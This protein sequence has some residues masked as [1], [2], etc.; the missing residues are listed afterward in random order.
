MSETKLQNVFGQGIRPGHP[1]ELM[2][3]TGADAGSI[4]PLNITNPKISI[5]ADLRLE[6][7][8]ELISGANKNDYHFKNIDLKR[9]VPSIKYYDIRTV[10]DGELTS[11]KKDKIRIT[12]AIEVGHIF[13]LGTKYSEALGSTFLDEQGNS[14]PIIMG[15]YGIGV[16][17]I[18][19]SHIEQNHDKF[20]IV[21]NGEIAPFRVQLICANTNI[22]DVLY[23]AEQTY[24]ELNAKGIDVLY[25][26]R[27]EISAGFKFKDADLIGTPIHIIIG[28]KN[29]KNGNVEIKIR[30]NGERHI[31]SKDDLMS[32]LPEFLKN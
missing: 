12:K 26:D 7:A 28:D 2:A 1:E 24:A 9:D 5:V 29:L 25:D 32:K 15:S 19:A 31:I 22:E 21:W 16:E 8:D 30:K 3:I 23:F 4:G 18:A 17:R 14:H 20:G 10:K 13:K 27:K 6:D 11:D